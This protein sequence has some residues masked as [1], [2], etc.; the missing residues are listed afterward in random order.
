MFSLETVD[1]YLHA[2]VHMRC[3][4]QKKVDQWLETSW[5]ELEVPAQ[6]L[7]VASGNQAVIA[8]AKRHL[9]SFLATANDKLSTRCA[10]LCCAV[11]RCAR[12]RIVTRVA[13][14]SVGLLA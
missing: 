3:S 13:V 12:R 14:C 7:A 9:L 10:V 8:E 6:A 2:C 1:K 4:D 11:L 5:N